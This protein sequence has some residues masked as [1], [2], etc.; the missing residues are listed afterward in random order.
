MARQ[1]DRGQLKIYLGGTPGAGKTFAMLREA[2]DL[3]R[4]GHD[5]VVGYVETYNRPRTGEL[6]N[7]LE[8]IPRKKVAYK[9]AAL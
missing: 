9:G 3:V 4:Q 5:V 6:L 8:V 1:A 2:H 7:G